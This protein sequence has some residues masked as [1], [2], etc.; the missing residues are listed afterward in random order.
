MTGS[1]WAARRSHGL[2]RRF[3]IPRRDEERLIKGRAGIDAQDYAV[4]RIEGEPAEGPIVLGMAVCTL[5]K[6]TTKLLALV[7]GHNGE[8]QRSGRIG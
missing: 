8:H 4:M 6:P 5:C 2:R 1:Y 3:L 7:S